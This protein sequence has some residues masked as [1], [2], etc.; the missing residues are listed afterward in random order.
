M[1]VCPADFFKSSGLF[2]DANNLPGKISMYTHLNGSKIL[3]C[4]QALP[5]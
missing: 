4:C 1:Q 3:F 5:E 2:I